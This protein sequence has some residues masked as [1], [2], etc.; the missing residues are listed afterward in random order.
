MSLGLSPQSQQVYNSAL[1]I[2][3]NDTDGSKERLLYEI[4]T[5][6]DAHPPQNEYEGFEWYNIHGDPRTLNSMVTRGLLNI[7]F[8]SNKYCTYRTVDREAVKRALTDYKGLLKPPE[9]EEIPTD[10]FRLVVGHEEKKE[11]I[12]RGISASTP[13]HFLLWGS[14]ASAKTLMLEELS[15]LPRNRF[16][17]GSSLTKAGIYEVLLNEK[18]RYLLVDELDKLDDQSNL[19]A[20]LSLME[21][22]IVTETKYRRHRRIKLE[23]WVFASANEIKRI[24]KE[25][26]SRFVLLKFRPYSDAEFTDVVVN[27]LREREGMDEGLAL[28]ISQKV[29]T[30]LGSRDVRDTVKIA[31]LMRGKTKAEVDHLVGILKKQK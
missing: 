5:W 10:L 9:D 2:L 30:E 4:V 3:T 17:L 18:P 24:P 11:I 22:G 28:Y 6:E 29:L 25:L 7:Q 20:L 27:V 23:T 12:M 26:L 19:T 16:V 8:K 13:V 31:R 21:T 1:V 14:V 15:R